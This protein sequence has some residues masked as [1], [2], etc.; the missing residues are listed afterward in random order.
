MKRITIFLYCIFFSM[1]LFSQHFPVVVNDTAYTICQVP[2]STD[3]LLN[4]YDLEGDSIQICR[5]YLSSHWG[6]RYYT[7]STIVFTPY[8]NTGEAIITYRICKTNLPDYEGE[9]Y[10]VVYIEE[11]PDI[12]VAV[13]DYATAMVFDTIEIKPLLNDYEVNVADIKIDKLQSSWPEYNDSVI[14]YRPHHGHVGIDSLR[15][16]VVCTDNSGLYSQYAN[17]IIQVNENPNLP[18]A[19]PDTVYTYDQMPT[20]VYPLENDWFPE[21]EEIHIRSISNMHHVFELYDTSVLFE[22]ENLDINPNGF[23]YIAA[24]NNNPNYYSEYAKIVVMLEDNPVKPV[25]NPDTLYTIEQIPELI[26]PLQN[27]YDPNNLPMKLDYVSSGGSILNDSTIA[28]KS[29]ESGVDKLSYS[30]IQKEGDSL[31]SNKE[32]IIIKVEENMDLPVT[33]DDSATTFGG[34]PVDIPVLI[35]DYDPNEKALKVYDAHVYSSTNQI[36]FNDS[37][38]TYTPGL[39]YIGNVLLTYRIIHQDSLYYSHD[40]FVFVTIL[41]NPDLPVANDD[42]FEVMPG[43]EYYLNLL[44][45]DFDPLGNSLKLRADQWYCDPVDD[46]SIYFKVDPDLL[47]AFQLNNE[48]KFD[49]FVQKKNNSEAYSR[50]KVTLKL[51]ENP[52][53]PVAVDDFGQTI[54]GIPVRINVLENDENPE[55]YPLQVNYIRNFYNTHVINED[56][57]VVLVPQNNFSGIDTIYYNCRESNSFQHSTFSRIILDVK[58]S[59]SYSE[60]NTNNISAGFNSYGF[61]FSN[62]NCR[63]YKV[64]FRRYNPRFES[65]KGSGLNSIFCSTIWMGGYDEQEILHLAA[66]F[67]N[68]NGEDYW[69]GPVLSE[70]DSSAYE[71]KWRKIWN[72]K[73]SKIKN[74]QD[75]WQSLHFSPAPEINYWPAGLDFL[76]ING[77]GYA[78]FYDLNKN[79]IYDPA[80]G[81]YP[82]IKGDEALYY[83]FNDDKYIHTET[84]GE[85]LG[86]EIHAMPYAFN[87]PEDSA[88]NNTVF[89]EYKL[90]NRSENTYS[91]FYIGNFVDFDLGNPWDDFMGC[92]TNLNLFFIYNGDDFDDDFEQN[93]SFVTGYRSFPPSTGVKVLNRKLNVFNR[94]YFNS[95]VYWDWWSPENYYNVIRG[96]HKYGHQM[97]YGG[98]GYD[99]L[100]PTSYF[101]PD[102]PSDNSGWS[103][104]AIWNY[105]GDRR[106]I[107]SIG[108]FTFHPGDTI[109]LEL[110]YIFA[111]DYE[112]DNISSVTLLKERAQTI[113]QYYDLG[114][115]PCGASWSVP[116]DR[117]DSFNELKLYPNPAREEVVILY[118]PV[119]EY[120]DLKVYDISGRIVYS[121]ILQHNIKH[122]VSVKELSSG[123]YL[124]IVQDG[125]N[126]ITKKLIKQQD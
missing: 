66:E 91:D 73:R 98:T 39:S 47:V 68:Q 55:G 88:F 112:G 41:K 122:Q 97:T 63:P 119:S 28:Y 108:P 71:I 78:P 105:P 123:L 21:G 5:C 116:T 77:N 53:W 89:V 44:E 19:I 93:D 74:H 61:N 85:K 81:D 83:I 37:I 16:R 109:E 45:N 101:Y 31:K 117:Q 26:Y 15:Y 125:D 100:I 29:F 9:G 8:N 1:L 126:T 90:I 106:A 2:V 12:P 52:G 84:G 113:Q 59:N 4:D 115:S 62:I 35:N 110:A 56:T 13:D 25:V 120:A 65:P 104:A 72:I 92:D 95:P 46:S 107:G 99:G 96:F 43:V 14:F 50:G 48:M 121:R 58:E 70:Y 24:L 38:I 33:I 87:C 57:A 34:I 40:A 82:L 114:I 64:S 103:E 20:M 32:R 102:D 67:Y 79:G 94:G 36:I 111:R 75:N 54:G 80:F 27:D 76:D 30:L 60:L 51:I 118:E 42:Y 69:A 18:I 86:V 10:L 17:I 49:Y 11:N 23:K 6:E 7:D 22:F 124:F 3:V